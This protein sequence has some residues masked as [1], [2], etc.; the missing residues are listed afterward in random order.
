MN[1]SQLLNLIK[2]AHQYYKLAV[3]L[4]EQVVLTQIY[5]EDKPIFRSKEPDQQIKGVGYN[6]DH[7]PLQPFT[8]FKE[9]YSRTKPNYRLIH[10]DNAFGINSP[11]TV[12]DFKNII[13]DHVSK[14]TSA[15]VINEGQKL[16]DNFDKIFSQ[17]A[18]NVLVRKLS[19]RDKTSPEAVDHDIFHQ[20]S[21]K[22]FVSGI[23]AFSNQIEKATF[24]DYDVFISNTME[25]VE[26]KKF[27]IKSFFDNYIASISF[28]YAL[29]V[30]DKLPGSISALNLSKGKMDDLFPD[31]LPIYNRNGETFDGLQFTGIDFYL[32]NDFKTTSL[33]P[34]VSDTEAS[35]YYFKPKDI[36]IP[37]LSAVIT[38]CLKVLETR[39][40]IALNDLVGKVLPLWTYLNV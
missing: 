3:P 6:K 17:D 12:E 40:K 33:N 16:I 20:I 8:Q 10:V 19:Y 1:Q 5:T 7:E 9:H 34:I 18:I 37:N 35:S 32:G 38:E 36:K 14:A 4:D 27:I 15:E 30:H 13:I 22:N 31:L 23:A 2:L 28:F 21:A 25:K 39:I 11:V 24:E 29:I 26:N